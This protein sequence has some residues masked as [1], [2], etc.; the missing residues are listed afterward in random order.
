MATQLAGWSSLSCSCPQRPTINGDTNERNRGGRLVSVKAGEGAGQ[1]KKLLCLSNGHGED[2]VAVSV[3]KEIKCM[4]RS[5]V[6]VEAIPLVGVGH[7]YKRSGISTIG[8]SRNMPSGGFINMDIVNLLWDIHAGLFSLFVLQWKT[9]E[10]WVKE[11]PDGTLLAVGD[12][13][14]LLLAWMASRQ[15]RKVFKQLSTRNGVKFIF[16]GTAK[17]EYHLRGDDGVPHKLG[18]FKNLDNYLFPRSVY[19]PWERAMMTDSSCCLVV[20]RDSFTVANLKRAFPVSAKAK[21]KYLGNPMMDNLKPSG[22]LDFL[23]KC[24]PA[25]FVAL[26]PGSRAP[27]V[28][29]NWQTILDAVENLLRTPI[30]NQ[31]IFLVPI[32]PYLEIDSFSKTLLDMGWKF[33][34]SERILH[35][36]EDAVFSVENIIASGNSCNGKND[37]LHSFSYKKDN[38]FILLIRGL[39]PDVASWADAGIAMTGTA[40][41]QLVGL[42]KPVFTMAGNGPQFTN[43]FAEAQSRLLGKSIILCSSSSIAKNM[44]KILGD[45]NYM[46]VVR[47]NGQKRMG[48]AGASRRIAQEIHHII[49]E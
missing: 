21:I 11:N 2:E 18:F 47:R 49:Y 19:F 43:V 26:F 36:A 8:P 48:S 32:V 30:S 42:G 37:I 41:E 27:E 38:A 7:A 45:N 44:S 6:V 10:N 15:M 28:Y 25:L 29:F 12:V 31:M 13:F 17:S 33:A 20:P 3:L 24:I 16:I 9:I 5:K 1:T 40:T 35:G 22:A 34:A 14:P 4:G 39:F 23:K 46:S